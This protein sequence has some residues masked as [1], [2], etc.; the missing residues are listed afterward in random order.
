M[1]CVFNMGIG[2]HLFV[3][4]KVAYAVMCVLKKTSEKP[5]LIGCLEKGTGGRPL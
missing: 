1:Y 3:R 2:A 4:A 5:I